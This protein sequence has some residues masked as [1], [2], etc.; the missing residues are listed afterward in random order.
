MKTEIKQIKPKFNP[1]EVSFQIESVEEMKAFLALTSMLSSSCAYN[2]EF[3]SMTRLNVGVPAIASFV[4]KILTC[5]QW[6]E[7][8]KTVKD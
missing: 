2:Y 7:L 3:V 4:D 6:E 8:F 5:D 1:V